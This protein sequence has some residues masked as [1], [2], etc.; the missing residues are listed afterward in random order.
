[1]GSSTV[2]P[3]VISILLSSVSRWALQQFNRC[4]HRFLLISDVKDLFYVFFLIFIAG[5]T[6]TYAWGFRAT[7]K[8]AKVIFYNPDIQE[9][10]A[11][12]PLLDTV[13]IKELYSPMPTKFNMVKNG[14]FEE[15]PHLFN[16]SINGVLLPSK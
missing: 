15:G 11:C 1:M 2:Q 3:C 5:S 10:P 4:L 13:A 6:N 16:D 12:G 7:S 8:V 14:D 9:N